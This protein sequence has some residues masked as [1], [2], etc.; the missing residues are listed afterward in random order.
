MFA[1]IDYL[2]D[3]VTMY[4]LVLYVLISFLAVSVIFSFFGVIAF[5]PI[6]IITSVLFTVAVSWFAN[7]L[8]AK[9]FKAPTNL[10]SVY[11]TALILSLIITPAE[12]IQGYI[13][14]GLTAIL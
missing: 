6:L 14:L 4:R 12:N 3:R 9:L 10:E 8:L 1:K 5:S 2:L 13:F 7:T 11:I